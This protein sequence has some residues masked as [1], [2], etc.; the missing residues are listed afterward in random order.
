MVPLRPRACCNPHSADS[1]S[2]AERCLCI[3]SSSSSTTAL[4]RH[5]QPVTKLHFPN[6]MMKLTELQLRGCRTA[7]QKVA[8]DPCKTARLEKLGHTPDAYDSECVPPRFVWWA[9]TS[10]LCHAPMNCTPTLINQTCSVAC[11][12]MHPDRNDAHNAIATAFAAK[13]LIL[14]SS[15]LH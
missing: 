6:N 7:L 15:L 13:L 2:D 4:A 3:P 9:S 12:A 14:A 11:R 10:G 5:S 1:R 8:N